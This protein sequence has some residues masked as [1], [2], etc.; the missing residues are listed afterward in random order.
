MSTQLLVHGPKLSFLDVVA[1]RAVRQRLAGLKYRVLALEDDSYVQSYGRL[2]ERCPLKSVLRAR[3]QRLYREVVF[4]GSIGAGEAYMQ[5]YFSV[6]DLTLLMRIIL[7]NRTVLN[8][9]EKGFARL[10]SPLQKIFYW[11]SRNT[12]DGSRKNIHAHY[13]LG[14]EL[15][16]LMLDPTMMYS[17]AYFEHSEMSLE[18]AVISYGRYRLTLFNYS[19]ALA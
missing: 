1:K 14:N 3:D 7:Q 16:E 18:D 2:A 8:G 11:T 4:G 6:D 15:F 17:G 5:G 10:L 13:D 19:Q 12:R 9:M